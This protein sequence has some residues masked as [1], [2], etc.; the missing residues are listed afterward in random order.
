PSYG[1][2]PWSQQAKVAFQKEFGPHTEVFFVFNGT[3]ANALSLRA[4]LSPHHAALC[5]DVSHLWNDECGAPEYLAGC[6]LIPL[7]SENGKISLSTLKE[8][9]TRRGD[10]HSSQ[11]RVLS[12]TQPTEL[13]TCYSLQELTDLISWAHAHNLLVHIDGSRLANA[14]VFLNCEFDELT[15]KLGV[16]MVSFGGTKNGFLFGEAILF[17]KPG[18]SEDF[19]Y[20][21]KQCGQ[22]PSKSRYIAA[23]FAA[24][25]ANQ[26]W[27]EIARHSCEMAARLEQGLKQYPLCQISQPRQSNAVFVKIPKAWVK[28]LKEASFFYVWNEKTF[29]CRWMTSWDTEAQDIDSFLQ[30]IQ[31]LTSS[32]AISS[33]KGVSQ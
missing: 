28:P 2:D 5:A 31:E 8:N 13:G 9:W 3:A 4:L 1:T 12:L 26:T 6:K 7:A 16:D 29:E 11:A 10:Q 27:K 33:D 25:L 18:L 22:L 19:Q 15:T 32:A 17:L 24:Y 14:C 21:R 20:I 30:V 23:Q